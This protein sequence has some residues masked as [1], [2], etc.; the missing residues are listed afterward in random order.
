MRKNLKVKEVQTVKTYLCAQCLHIIPSGAN[1]IY[2]KF[3]NDKGD[4]YK[5]FWAGH[6]HKKCYE[7]AIKL[8]KELKL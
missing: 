1:A 4:G 3:I 5:F 7:F 2:R 8:E 6:Y